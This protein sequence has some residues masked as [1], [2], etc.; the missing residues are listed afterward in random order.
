[1]WGDGVTSYDQGQDGEPNALG[2]CSVRYIFRSL[3]ITQL[4]LLC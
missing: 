1:M 3:Y 4:F 2:A